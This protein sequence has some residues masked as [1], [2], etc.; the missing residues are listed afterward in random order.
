MEDKL[1]NIL[2]D[3]QNYPIMFLWGVSVL[4]LGSHPEPRQGTRPAYLAQC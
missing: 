4:E 3:E 1:R 2:D